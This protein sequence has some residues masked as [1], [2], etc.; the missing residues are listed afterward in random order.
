MKNR[1]YIKDLK[2]HVGQEAII[3]G[4]VDV[5]RDQ[6]KMVFFD[7]RDMTG[8]V[9]CVVLPKSTAMEIAGKIRPEWVLKITGN[10]N[11]RPDK[12]INAGVLNGDI[13][14]EV[15][16]IEILNKAETPPFEI[17][18]NT[19][20]VNEDVRMKYKYLDLRTERMQKNIRMR[21][22]AIKLIR[23]F[24]DKEGFIEVETPILTKST[25]EGARD[26]VVPS[27]IWQGM[28]YALPQAPQQ[29]K[30]LLM[31][32][33]VEKYFQIAKCMRDEDT[34]GDRQPEFTQLDLEMS[35][36]KRE[37]VMELN[38]RLLVEIV[39][40]LYPEKKIQELPFPRLS[41]EEAVKKY[42]T[43]RPDLRKGKKNNDLLAFC[44]VVDFPFFEKTNKSDNPQAEGE[45]TFTHNPFSRPQEK[46]IADLLAKKN[47][48]NILTDQYDVVLNGSE[49][50][51]GSIRNHEPEALRKVFEI[52]G[53]KTEDIEK[54]F[55]H[56]LHAFRSGTP[57]HGGIAWGLDRILMILQD[58]PSIREVIAF[59]KTGEGRDLMMGAP[60]EISDKQLKELGIKLSK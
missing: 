11:K 40:T 6:G 38:E 16:G 49:I 23:D 46:N 52:L 36:V 22:K 45:W 54:N 30:Q 48:A 58:E 51:G 2:D 3:A 7:M 15:T 31:T 55:G 9:Q 37:D 24:L 8:K 39:K 21:H 50:G 33:G 29:Y 32:G 25:P 42:D 20:A 10:V 27:R 19:I 12:N 34:R 17:N 47:V 26:Y 56:M 13:E 14:L 41:Y 59:P 60:T 5:R 28:F 4:W 53:H 43:D 44:W 57:P 35:F 1:V 18:E